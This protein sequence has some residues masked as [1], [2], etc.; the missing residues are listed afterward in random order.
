M[1][2]LREL[3]RTPSENTPPLGAE[4]ACQQYVARTLQNIGLE[5]NVYDLRDVPGL[6]QHALYFPGRDYSERPNVGAVKKGDGGGRSLIL[7]G[8]IDTVPRGSQPWMHEPFG[9][10]VEE[11]RLYGRGANDMKCGVATNLFVLEALSEMKVSLAGDLF[12]E[13]VVDEEFGG[14]NGTLA[15]R[16]NGYI[17]D[18]AIISEP[19][20]LRICAAQRG[21]RT[22]HIIFR[23]AGGVLREDKLGTGIIEQ[24]NFFLTKLNDFAERRRAHVQIHELY[25]DHIDPVPVNVTKIVTSLWGTKEPITIPEQC[26]IELYWQMMPGEAQTDIEVEFFSWLDSVV[27]HADSPFSQRPHVSFPIRWLPGSAISKDEPLIL[28]LARS[29]TRVLGKS[30][31]V[32]G[33]EGPCDLYI[34]QQAFGIPAV[35][36]GAKGGNTHA[37]DEYV[38]I[39]SVVQA[40]KTLLLF[41][42]EWC[43]RSSA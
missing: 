24:V 41:V 22:A 12:F 3:V 36:W 16:L 29:A 21:G 23:A 5:A 20:S 1:E 40:A 18:A 19:S 8:H 25:R 11:N 6:L 31:A 10:E 28:E 9:G 27:H 32:A 14:S 33:I 42:C 43:G 2:I 17:A 34:F 15:G 35:L 26:Q 30:P 7:S 4:A 37:A 38:E 13:S 39:D